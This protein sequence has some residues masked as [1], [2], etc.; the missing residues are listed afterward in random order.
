VFRVRVVRDVRAKLCASPPGGWPLR[1]SRVLLLLLLLLPPPLPRWCPGGVPVVS[2]WCPLPQPPY[3][4]QGG[5]IGV[6]IQW[7][8]LG[9]CV[10]KVL[11]RTRAHERDTRTNREVCQWLSKKKQADGRARA[12][13][14]LRLER[15]VRPA[16]GRSHDLHVVERGLPGRGR[17]TVNIH[18]HRWDT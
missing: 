3:H 9:R 5:R 10:A 1:R 6:L 8:R 11:P 7:N 15:A 12:R 14:P 16:A 18:H 2:R 17:E 13:V 4:P